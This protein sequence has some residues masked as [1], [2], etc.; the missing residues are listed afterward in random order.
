MKYA[1]TTSFY[2][3]FLKFVMYSNVRKLLIKIHDDVS[4]QSI[5]LIRCDI[6]KDWNVDL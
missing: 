6:A 1:K 2:K 3:I 4:P 5:H